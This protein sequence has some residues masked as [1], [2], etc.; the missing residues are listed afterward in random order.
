M[1]CGNRADGRAHALIT[2]F[3]HARDRKRLCTHRWSHFLIQSICHTI[4]GLN[5]FLNLGNSESFTMPS[6]WLVGGVRG[7]I[8]LA[9]KPADRLGLVSGIQS[10][11]NIDAY[12]RRHLRLLQVCC[13]FAGQ[14]PVDNTLLDSLYGVHSDDGTGHC[15]LRPCKGDLNEHQQSSCRAE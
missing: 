5:R 15:E 1:S 6:R 13:F 14:F 12:M 4:D 10:A 8:A 9:T 11:N 7:M 2:F 3:N